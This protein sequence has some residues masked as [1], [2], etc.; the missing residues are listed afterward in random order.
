MSSFSRKPLALFL[1]LT[2]QLSAASS[3][4]ETAPT[5]LWAHSAGGASNDTALAVAVDPAGNILVTGYFNGTMAIGNTNLV[6]SGAED[7]FLAKFDSAGNPAWVRQ[8]GGIGYDEGRGVA[9]DAAGNVYITGL[10]QNTASFGSFNVNSAGFSDVYIAKYDPSGNVVWVVSAGGSDYDEAHAIAVDPVGNAYITGFFDA[11]ASF[12]SFS[13]VNH[14]GSDDIF[15]AKCSSTGT[16][17]W[18]RQAGG[19]LDDSGECIALDASTNV[20]VAGSFAGTT[21]FGSTNLTSAGTNDLPDIFLAKY[22]SN[23]NALWVRQAGGAGDDEAY[24]IAADRT[25]NVSITGRF[26]SPATFGNTNLTG[27]GTDIFVARY[28]ALGNFLWA[29]RSGG[30]NSIYGDSGLGIAADASGNTFVTG[31]FSGNSSFGSTNLPTAGF[32]DIFCTK[33]DPTGNLLWVRAAGG[34]N[35]DISYGIAADASGSVFLAGFFASTTITFDAVTLTNTGA[36]D[37]FVTKLAPLPVVPPS[38]SI[39]LSNGLVFLSWPAAATDFTLESTSDLLTAPWG[40]VTA[41]SGIFGTNRLLVLPP[42][43]PA[44]FFRLHQQ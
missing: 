8:A 10:Y 28:D 17:L 22:D 34:A 39:T 7:I 12:G 3:R 11:N 32:D 20:Y 18:A 25:G 37:I 19:P 2:L 14:S 29:R 31:Y 24:G 6:S 4:A 44:A 21:T 35:L 43:D 41:Q 1:L 27:N 40:P 23:G 38:L 9:T 30:N 26:A 36:R 5:F 15:V 42:S 33:Y 16:F 13:L